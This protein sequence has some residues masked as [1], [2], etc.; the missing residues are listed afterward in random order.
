[1]ALLLLT[2]YA[3]VEN[4]GLF[5]LLSFVC[6]KTLQ[7]EFPK[8]VSYNRF[9]ELSQRVSIPMI[10]L[11]QSMIRNKC[12][13]ISFIDSTPIRVCK[14]QSIHNHTVFKGIAQG[15]IAPLVISLG[16]NYT[17]SSMKKESC[18][19]IHLLRPISMMPS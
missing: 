9:I 7:A 12:T 4:K 8:T 2:C 14:N 11:L 19:T 1:M 6:T 15:D 16:S 18:S 13:G 3:Q 17:S 5:Y 10:L